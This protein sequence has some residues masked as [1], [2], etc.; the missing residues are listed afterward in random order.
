[1]KTKAGITTLFMFLISL[2][3]N[4]QNVAFK[5]TPSK[6]PEWKALIFSDD[7]NMRGG[8]QF[9][10]KTDVCNNK[11]VTLAKVINTNQYMVK[12]S[13]QISDESPVVSLVIPAFTS[14]EGSCTASDV[15]TSKLLVD[16]PETSSKEEKDK[17]NSFIIS[18]ISVTKFQ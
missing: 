11:K 15:N 13:Y 3:V 18:H 6:R 14:L 7:F 10:T 8:V 9:Y 2:F 12:L 5:E 16:L 17:M 4:G 1:M